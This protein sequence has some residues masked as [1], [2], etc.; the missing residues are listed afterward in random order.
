MTELKQP[1]VNRCDPS[2]ARAKQVKQDDQ[3]VVGTLCTLHSC[4]PVYALCTLH[5][6]FI[7]VLVRSWK[8]MHIIE[9][10]EKKSFE[11][12]RQREVIS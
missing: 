7:N 10:Y 2:E 12:G 3:N 4:C 11:D 6:C 8:A 5:S 9:I 1:S